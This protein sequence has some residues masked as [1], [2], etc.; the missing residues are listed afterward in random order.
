MSIRPITII[1]A[2]LVLGLAGLL[3]LPGEVASPKQETPS[4]RIMTTDW[5][6]AET[7]AALHVPFVGM[8]EKRSYHKWVASPVLSDD[9]VDFGM[10]V[11]PNLGV[12][13]SL[14]PTLLI[15]S[16]WYTRFLPA[17]LLKTPSKIVDFFPDNVASWEHFTAATRLTGEI[18]GY[19]DNADKLIAQTQHLLQQ[20]AQQLAPYAHRPVAVVQFMD[21][22]TV[23]IYGDNSLYGVA[24]AQLGLRNAWNKPTDIW[25]NI[26]VPLTD[27][28][29]FSSDTIIL[30]IRPLPLNIDRLLNNNVVWQNLPA[31]QPGNTHFLPAIWSFG[32]LV[33]LQRFSTAATQ[34]IVSN[35]EAALP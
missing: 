19:T 8:G 24:L 27:L 22:R 31:N 34:A 29:N 23:R 5:A 4:E 30:A 18:T 33:S 7:L 9:V 16:T 14:R 25:G 28:A 17:A 1:T 11:Q 6:V 10:R 15:N 35:Q 32:G 2:T 26:V 13:E 20:Q 3:L 21:A 12:L